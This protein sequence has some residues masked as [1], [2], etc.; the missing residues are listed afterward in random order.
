MNRRTFL[1]GAG[2]AAVVGVALAAA[3][4]FGAATGR[5]FG[6]QLWSV[7]RM[8][9]EDFEGTIAMLAGLGYRELET[10]GPYTFSDPRQI[11]NWKKTA[12]MLGFSGSGFFGL[13][14][15]QIG[16]TFARHGLTVP[17]MH[18]DLFTLQTRMGELA[19]AAHALGATYV[20]LPSL[21]A[22][23]RQTFDDYKRAADMFNAIGK[24]ATRHGVRFAY[25]NHGYGLVPVGGKV[26]LETLIEATDPAH[27][28]LEMDTYWSTAGGADCK[29]YLARYKGRYRMVHLK[30]MKGDH[31]FPGDGGAPSDWIGMFPYLTYL[32]DGSLDMAGIIAAAKESG[33]EHFFVEQ[34]RA[35]DLKVAIAGSAAYMKKIGFE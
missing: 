27:V 35:D 18:T 16:A 24:D 28:F 26:P 15:A 8:L 7:A 22:D 12:A 10:Y 4:S 25:H 34:D 20:T 17:S 14:T 13:T 19:E 2:S 33:V 29:A 5:K 6:I 11:E 23:Q 3:P 30:D 21:P 32:G 1:A 9:S 31:R